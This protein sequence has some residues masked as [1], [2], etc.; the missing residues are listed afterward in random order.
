MKIL[1]LT[2]QKFGRLTVVSQNPIKALSGHKR[3]NC[4]APE[5]GKMWRG[6]FLC[7]GQVQPYLK[8]LH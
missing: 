6:K 3:W 1:E 4:F 5:H 2:N 7:S 8:K